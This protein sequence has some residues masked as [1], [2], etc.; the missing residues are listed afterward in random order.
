M[1]HELQVNERRG[2]DRKNIC[3]M[4]TFE[5]VRPFLILTN[6]ILKLYFDTLEVVLK[7]SAN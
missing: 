1:K 3:M 2:Q 4:H 5:M 7:L 6:I